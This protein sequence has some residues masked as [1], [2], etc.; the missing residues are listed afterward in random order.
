MIPYCS[1]L[2]PESASDSNS[3]TASRTILTGNGLAVACG[4]GALRLE[5]LQRPGGKAL[6][7]NAFLR[8]FALPE[9]LPLPDVAAIGAR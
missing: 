5:K 6:E 7:A 1:S 8:G 4:S 3:A 2:R 9:R